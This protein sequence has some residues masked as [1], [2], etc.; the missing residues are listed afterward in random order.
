MEIRRCANCM[1]E[2]TEEVCP[3]CGYHASQAEQ[4]SYALK[5]NTILH[6]R[7]LVGNMLG[8]GGF[9]ITYIGFD[10]MLNIKVAIKEYYPMGYVSRDCTQSNRIV[11]GTTKNGQTAPQRGCEEFLKEARRMAQIDVL[12]EIVRVRDTFMDNN[13]AYIVMDYVQGQTLKA[14]LLQNGVMGF[15]ECVGMLLPLMRSLAEV[16][17]RGMIHRD[18]SPDNIMVETDGKLRLLDLGSAKELNL[19]DSGNSQLVTKK[20]FSPVEQCLEGGRVGTWTDVYA[21]CA[22]IYYCITGKLAPDS[23]ERMAS[24]KDLLSFDGQMKEPL[25]EKAKTILRKGLAVKREDRIQTVEELVDGLEKAVR[26]KPGDNILKKVGVKKIVAGCAA[27]LVVVFVVIKVWNVYQNNLNE[28]IPPE[29]EV[30]TTSELTSVVETGTNMEAGTEPDTEFPGPE[31]DYTQN[32]LMQEI[33]V[34]DEDED[35]WVLGKEGLGRSSIVSVNFLDSL[36]DM[37]DEAWDVSKEKNGNVMAWTTSVDNGLYHLFISGTGGVMADNCREQFA[38]YDNVREILFN[39]CFYTEQMTNANSMFYRCEKLE[40]IE[41]EQLDTS[42]VEDMGWM[43]CGCSSLEQLDLAGVKTGKATNMRSMFGDCASLKVL[44]VSGFDTKNVTTMQNMFNGCSSLKNLEMGQWNT[45]HVENMCGMFYKCGGLETIELDFNTSQVTNMESMFDGCSAL[46]Q[47]D[48]SSFITG[49][50]TNMSVM[51]NDCSALKALDV[52]TF[53]TG[54]VTNM[55]EM[56]QHCSGLET[57]DVSSF[58]TQNVT[59]MGWMFYDCSNIKELDVS[60]FSTENVM[61]MSGMF[62]QCSSLEAIDVSGFDT[63]NVTD[64]TNMFYGCSNVKELDVSQFNTGNVTTM[65]AMFYQCSSLERLDVSNFDTQ[66]V[67]DMSHMFRNCS[68]VKELDVSSFDTQ[69]VTNMSYMFCGCSSLQKLDLS[70]FDMSQVSKREEMLED[71]PIT[72]EEAGLE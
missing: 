44:D 22:T 9:G 7:Y 2:T 61:T 14:F 6:G 56:F 41:L 11:W 12:P 52:S 68:N 8:Q 51:F 42:N 20:G 59:D 40:H 38:Y 16:H 47:I 63:Q 28:V 39:K 65:Y 70:G 19:N 45:G 27:A 25:G 58:D 71:V 23:L 69:N 66:N 50:V 18:I 15:A 4:T 37:P 10:M 17:K 34:D 60:K 46:E 3:Y 5:R 55:E 64:M 72:E 32:V 21:L 26:E 31:Y 35:K 67:T 30:Y 24:D 13:T 57:L 33:D 54:S 43:F 1:E 29:T 48:L 62:D 53:N 36:K 49:R